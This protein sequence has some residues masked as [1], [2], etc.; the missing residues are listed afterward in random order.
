M[1][2]TRLGT[3]KKTRL[4][5]FGNPR[6]RGIHAI[7]LDP[8]DDL[9]AVE[10]TTGENQIFLGTREGKCIRFHEKNVRAVGRTARGV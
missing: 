9:L 4:T 8:G 1:F 10:L 2:A 5:A 6:S 3:V 7:N